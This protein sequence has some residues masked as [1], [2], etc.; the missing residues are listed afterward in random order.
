MTTNILNSHHSKTHLAAF[1]VVLATLVVVLL[2][3]PPYYHSNPYNSSIISSGNITPMPKPGSAGITS[4]GI[5]CGPGVRQVPWSHYAPICEPA[6]HGNNGGATSPGV[7]AKT[8]TVSYRNFA[9]LELQAFYT[10]VPKSVMGTNANMLQGLMAYVKLFNKDYELYG[11]HVVVKPF[12]GKGDLVQELA[13]LGNS[14]AQQDAITAK[15]LGAFADMSLL[16][17]SPMYQKY[18]SDQGIISFTFY[19]GN[20][21]TYESEAPYAYALNDLCGKIVRG[22]AAVVDRSMAGLPAIFAGDPTYHTKTRVFGIISPDLPEWQSC[23]NTLVNQL[24]SYGI[25]PAEVLSYTANVAVLANEVVAVITKMKS[26]GVTTVL[27]PLCDFASPILWAIE[28]DMQNYH[29]EWFTGVFLD[30]YSQLIK[31]DQWSHALGITTQFTPSNNQSGSRELEAYK[32]FKLEDPKGHYIVGDYYIYEAAIAFF[33]ALQAAG[34]D[35]TPKTFQKGFDSLPPSIP[36]G[37]YGRWEFSPGHFDPFS[38]FRIVWWNATKL[39]TE[40][41]RAGTWIDCN[42]GTPYYFSNN[43]AGLPYHQQLNCF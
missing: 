14:A 43:A 36:N 26:A 41:G 32:A 39:S 30:G 7:T 25:T 42:N 4:S 12:T 22:V 28:A 33:D 40:D 16:S 11:R 6:W 27:C 18:L 20:R 35:L 15:S 29:P 2:L 38:N 9:S 1:I 3:I 21:A 13:G 17:V 34:P 10:F 24:K 8:I 31:K 23:T 5:K 19:G 37:N